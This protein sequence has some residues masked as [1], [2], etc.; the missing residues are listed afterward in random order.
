MGKLYST[1]I[2]TATGIKEIAAYYGD[3]TCFE[4]SIDILTTSAFK[5]SYAPTPRTVFKALHD[6][7]I[8]VRGLALSPFIDLRKSNNIWLSQELSKNASGISR[9]GCIELSSYKS[10][11]T[12][13]TD[14]HSLLC[15]IR[16]YFYML[17]L[18]SVNGIKMETVAL[19]L[20]GSGSQGISPELLLIPLINEC[21]DFLKRNQ[22]VKNIYFIEKNPDKAMLIAE[23]LKKSYRFS[24]KVNTEQES[25]S[26]SQATA[27]ISYSSKDKNIADNLCAKLERRRIKVWYAPRN[28]DGPYAESIVQAI[29][30]S[31]YFIVILSENSI[32][33]QHVLSEV[34]LAF[35]NLPN[36]IKFK[37][38]KIDS[39]MFTPSFKYYL[40]RQHWMDA[41]DPPLEE[42]LS[43]FVND[44]V[45]DNDKGPH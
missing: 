29:D 10:A 45:E 33:S 28:V 9:I 40:S 39:A 4:K 23:S 7:G 1:Q 31:D 26:E 13:F 19:P 20:L 12:S 25:N 44:L 24:E 42:R 37:P 35:Q 6:C 27:F 34:D 2:D 16:S 11:H 36:K 15:S 17:D 21:I 14:E 38:L 32:Q 22:S 43:E 8:S 30:S 18:A 41:I 5:G 3:V